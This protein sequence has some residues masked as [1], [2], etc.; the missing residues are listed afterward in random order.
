MKWITINKPWHEFYDTDLCQ[1]GVLVR[2]A[3]GNHVLIGDVNSDGGKCDC[4]FQGSYVVAAL[5][6]R[7][8][9]VKMIVE[10][11]NGGNEGFPGAPASTAAAVPT[12]GL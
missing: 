5:D 4:C 12:G 6:L 11:D 3:D 10:A 9:I 2:E 7:G 1:P 8:V